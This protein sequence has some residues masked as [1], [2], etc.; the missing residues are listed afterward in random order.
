MPPSGPT[1]PEARGWIAGEAAKKLVNLYDL[2]VPHFDADPEAPMADGTPLGFKPP[3]DTV[4]IYVGM[5]PVRRPGTDTFTL[6]VEPLRK[7]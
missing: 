2:D 1:A 7:P 6:F 3:P 5:K 4:V